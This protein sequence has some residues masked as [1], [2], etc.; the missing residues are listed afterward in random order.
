MF[1]IV[2]VPVPDELIMTAAGYLV[3]KGFLHPELTIITAFMGSACGIS[4]SYTIGRVAGTR[5]IDKFG[6]FVH[7]TPDR[8]KFVE[9]WFRRF[10]KWTLVFGYFITGFR[11]VIA[12][13]A[14]TVKLRLAAFALF[15]YAGALLW[16]LTFISLGYFLGEKWTLIAEHTETVALILTAIVCVGAVIYFLCR[17]GTWA[18]PGKIVGSEKQDQR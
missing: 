5:I 16:S 9:A 3:F 13:V 12:I 14:G 4:L 2:G 6:H 10:G 1:G 18:K 11:H 8:L 15:A 17:R 7:V